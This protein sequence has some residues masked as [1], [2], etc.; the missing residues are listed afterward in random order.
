MESGCAVRMIAT[1]L[2]K[3]GKNVASK[4]VLQV[5]STTSLAASLIIVLNQSLAS[6]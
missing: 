6:R 2:N 3:K 5:T 4:A 1:L